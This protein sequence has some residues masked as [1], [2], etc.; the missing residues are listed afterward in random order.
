[1]A[2]SCWIPLAPLPPRTSSRPSTDLPVKIILGHPVASCR[3]FTCLFPFSRRKDDVRFA[4]ASRQSRLLHHTPRYDRTSLAP[5]NRRGAKV[6][7]HIEH[8][9]H[10]V[11]SATTWARRNDAMKRTTT[12]FV[13]LISIIVYNYT[14]SLSI[15]IQSTVRKWNSSRV[16]A[17]AF[18]YRRDRIQISSTKATDLHKSRM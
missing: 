4:K 1:M 15:L 7:E 9:E 8:V 10:A 17:Y 12:L 13:P 14:L 18:D 2:P 16:H 6:A 11:G 3:A 5:R